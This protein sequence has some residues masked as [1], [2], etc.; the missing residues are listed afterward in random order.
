MLDI[1]QTVAV[2]AL[3]LAISVYFL[4]QRL[5]ISE[6]VCFG[7]AIFTILVVTIFWTTAR[8]GTESEDEDDNGHF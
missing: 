5:G 7:S 3:M 4:F 2:L 8:L 1:H 6:K